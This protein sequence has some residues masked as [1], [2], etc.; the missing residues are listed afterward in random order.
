M[1]T[2]KYRLTSYSYFAYYWAVG[3][4][5]ETKPAWQNTWTADRAATQGCPE[6]YPRCTNPRPRPH[7][8]DS[9]FVSPPSTSQT[10]QC[11]TFPRWCLPLDEKKIVFSA[12][13]KSES[14][15]FLLVYSGIYISGECSYSPRLMEPG[16]LSL[17]SSTA[18][19]GTN[20]V[21]CTEWNETSNLH[22][23]IAK[24]KLCGRFCIVG[25]P[26]RCNASQFNYHPSKN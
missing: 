25:V 3:T 14:G 19:P 12:A 15:K 10:S 21:L 26:L 22:V 18:G 9:Y 23:L 11:D 2:W 13:P 1:W 16:S 5:Y 8:N 7:S 20:D 24:F 4:F 6:S 17:L